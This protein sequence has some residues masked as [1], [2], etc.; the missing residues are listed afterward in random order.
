MYSLVHKLEFLTYVQDR[1]NILLKRRAGE[2]FPWTTD[3][4]LRNHS[5]CNIFREDDRTTIWFRENIRDPLKDDA[6]VFMATVA[7]RWFNRISTGELIKD[8]LLEEGWNRQRVLERLHGVAPLITGAY[9]IKSPPGRNKLTGLCAC[10]ENVAKDADMITDAIHI[11]LGIKPEN[12]T[13]EALWRLLLKYPYLGNFMSY[14][15]VTD[16][17]H[18]WM[19]RKAPD[20]MTWCSPGPGCARGM[21]RVVAKDPKIFKYTS[22]IDRE[23]VNDLMYELLLYVNDHLPS[24]W[25]RWE[26]REVEHTLCEYDKYRRGV[27]RQGRLKKLYRPPEGETK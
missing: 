14:E 8:I 19:G 18:T 2:P 26:M 13:L 15:I 27:L 6:K 25:E 16:L 17:R 11:G 12:V 9:M 23:V 5:F 20:I 24:G 4:V 22:A 1:Q 3:S 21:G 10:I 7:F